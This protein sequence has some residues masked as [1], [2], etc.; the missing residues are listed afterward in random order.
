[1]GLWPPPVHSSLLW[2]ILPV[3]FLSGLG[4][5]PKDQASSHRVLAVC[6]AFKARLRFKS[7]PRFVYS[8]VHLLLHWLHHQ[9][10]EYPSLSDQVICSPKRGDGLQEGVARPVSEAIK[11]CPAIGSR[12]LQFNSRIA[13]KMSRFTPVHRTTVRCQIDHARHRFG[14]S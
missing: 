7:Q 3:D 1:M 6:L 2:L 12:S 11:L 9:L 10:G 13:L 5:D 8:F 14:P 4:R